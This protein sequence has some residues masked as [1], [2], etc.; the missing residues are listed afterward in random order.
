MGFLLWVLM[1]LIVGSIAKML[2]KGQHDLGCIGTSAL[3]LIG[4]IVGGTVLNI[5][6]GRGS[7]VTTVGFFGS[8]LGAVIVLVIARLLS[9]KPGNI[10]R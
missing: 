8:I 7:D 10:R 9:P 5:I 6:A 1:G 4:S 2:V 3:G